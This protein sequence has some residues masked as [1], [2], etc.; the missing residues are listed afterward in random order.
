M[1]ES[2]QQS[3]DAALHAYRTG[4]L[5][6]ESGVIS[7]WWNGRMVRGP[8]HF[9]VE[10]LAE[11]AAEWTRLYGK[12]QVHIERLS[13]DWVPQQASVAVYPA[14]PAP[15]GQIPPPAIHMV[16]HLPSSAFEN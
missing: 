9:P 11:C 8:E 3:I 12:G 1:T 10:D 16:S 13:P 6:A 14:Q 2:V 4:Q 7:Y 15:P 5:R